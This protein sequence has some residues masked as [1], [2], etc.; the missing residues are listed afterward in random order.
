MFGI[1]KKKEYKIRNSKSSSSNTGY[2]GITKRS[3]SGK[4]QAQLN[5]YLRPNRSKVRQKLV[6]STRTNT[7]EEAIE[8]REKYIDSLY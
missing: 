1:F 2:K 4:Y 6:W 8:A 7:L 5:V 3:D